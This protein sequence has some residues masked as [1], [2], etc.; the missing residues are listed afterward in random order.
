MGNVCS[1][2]N[3][4]GQYMTHFLTQNGQKNEF[5]N[6]NNTLLPGTSILDQ[7]E[8]EERYNEE[9]KQTAKNI[10]LYPSEVVILV[11]RMK[12]I[13]VQAIVKGYL[14]RKQFKSKLK[15]ELVVK[16]FLENVFVQFNTEELERKELAF[17]SFDPK[18]WKKF[19]EE[20]SP[21]FN[22]NYGLVFP[23]S[24]RRNLTNYYIGDMNMNDEK[25]GLGRLINKAGVIYHGHWLNDI[26]HGWGR[27]LY[28][29]EVLF[30]GNISENYLILL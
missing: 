12:L 28:P 9:Y 30:E 27:M 10:D 25:H 20:D 19:Y 4:D 22:V 2:L 21:L 6:K 17:R 23:N 8:M 14:F 26:F 18:G 29:N 11:H 13:K 5:L 24:L 1:C 16:N 7:L 3:K 15:E